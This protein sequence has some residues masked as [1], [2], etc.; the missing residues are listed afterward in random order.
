MVVVCC[1]SVVVALLVVVAVDVGVVAVVEVDFEG[2]SVVGCCGTG[3]LDDPRDFSE[4][5]DLFPD[6]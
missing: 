3:V 4:P 6:A 5:S 1:R 2:D